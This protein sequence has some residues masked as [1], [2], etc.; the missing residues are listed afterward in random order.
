MFFPSLFILQCR[1][2][3]D[4]LLLYDLR[5]HDDDEVLRFFFFDLGGTLHWLARLLGAAL[6]CLHFSVSIHFVWAISNGGT[7]RVF[8]ELS[9]CTCQPVHFWREMWSVLSNAW[10]TCRC[11]NR[12]LVHP[13]MS[14]FI[15]HLLGAM[16]E[17]AAPGL[18][19]HLGTVL[20]A[21]VAAKP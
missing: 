15:A 4:F 12:K 19:F 18:D 7:R 20:P 11:I 16:A 21:L 14:P 3:L 9:D 5:R 17:I 2:G 1:P 8:Y 10:M 13:P 6:L